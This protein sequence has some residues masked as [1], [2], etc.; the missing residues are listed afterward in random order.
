MHVGPDR[1]LCPQLKIHDKVMLT[2]E[3][4]KYLGVVISSNTKIEENI[5]MR[6][7]KGTGI[8]NQIIS[9][10]KEV[11]FGFY[12]FEMGLLFR[13][14]LLIN[15]IMFNLEV[16]H[17]LSTKHVDLIEDCDKMFMRNFFEIEAGTPIEAFYIET[18]TLPLKY[19]LMAR[20]LMYYHTLLK[21]GESELVKRVFL[22]QTQFPTKKDWYSEVKDTL[23]LCGIILTEDEISKC[24]VYKFKNLVN[25]KVK[26]RASD[27]LT[28]LQM[29]H[30]KT[31]YLHQSDEMKEYLRSEELT[32]TE[33]KWLFRMR[34]R[35][36]PNK[37]N[38]EGRYKPDLSFSLRKN[39]T[40]KE[41]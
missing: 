14:S 36:C 7:A 5:K 1:S 39:K 9:I 38:F 13:N 6:H 4:E 33:K 3:Q 10:M 22:A 31:K 29:K 15:G 24:S 30:S 27:D 41:T 26:Q 23:T 35:M 8:N 28:K 21:K 20:Q 17:N 2:T 40:I 12:Y 37:T 18:A 19:T 32:T 11:S 25:C 34:V 16:I